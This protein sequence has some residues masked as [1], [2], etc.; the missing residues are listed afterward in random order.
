VLLQE[1]HSGDGYGVE[2]LM[3]EGQPICAFQHKRLHE[4]PITGG[5]SSLR[6]SVNLDP[7]LYEHS[8][9]MLAALNWTGLAMVEFKLTEDGMCLMEING[10]VWGSLPLAVHSGMD[11][12][13]HL[14]ELY[15]SESPTV[16]PEPD[17]QYRV[18]VRARNL[19]LDIVWLLSVLRGNRRHPNIEVPARSELVPAICGY[20]NPLYKTDVQSWDD[21]LPGLLELPRIATRLLRK[22]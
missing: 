19:N 15:L 9:R 7:I 1:Y 21:P 18:G 6:E 4:V 17:T 2:L 14:A 8:R 11:F 13:A 5:A 12:P 16:P 3:F 22:I 20:F 10:R